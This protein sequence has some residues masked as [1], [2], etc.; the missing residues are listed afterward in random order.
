MSTGIDLSGR[1]AVV[2]G[3]GG[4]IGGAI[5]DALAGAGAH[6]VVVEIDERR[7]HDRL[8][9]ITKAGGSA[10]AVVTDVLD[11]AQVADAVASA[12]KAG[13]VDIL[14]N[15]VGHYLR[16]TPFLAS[17]EQH[18]AALHDVNFLH[19]LRFSRALMPGMVERGSGSVIN[20]ASV[21]GMRGYPPDPVYGAYKAAVIHF[22][23]CLALEV[24]SSGVRVNA[25]APDVTQSLQVDYDAMVP[26]ELQDHWPVWVPIGRVGVPADNADVVLFLASDLSRFV[27][28]HVIPT[29]GG[30]VAAGGWFRT[31]RRGRWT[32]RPRDP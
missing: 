4:G 20:V 11:P 24:A 21:E 2:T 19:V 3:G 1:R 26:A 22:T 13:P 25:I 32:N 29:D 7:G 18:W 27:T 14:V 15:N 6:V 23:R 10:E 28:G 30:T 31:M 9:A 17:D 12:T 5:S 8:A 16:P